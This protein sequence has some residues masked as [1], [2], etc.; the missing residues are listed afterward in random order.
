MSRLALAGAYNSQFNTKNPG[1]N[2]AIGVSVALPEQERVKLIQRR[3]QAL[4][5]NTADH[6]SAALPSES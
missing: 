4:L 2:V 1:V 3:D 6:T 5:A